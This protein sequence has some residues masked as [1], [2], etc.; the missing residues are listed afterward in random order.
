[1]FWW[2]LT[3]EKDTARHPASSIEKGLQFFAV[4]NQPSTIINPM[5]ST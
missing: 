3:Y 5:S 2:V 1:L 4:I